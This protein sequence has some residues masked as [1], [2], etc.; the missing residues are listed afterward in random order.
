MSKQDN[1][2]DFLTDVA[3]AIREKKGSSDLI[4]PQNFSEEI[5]NLPSGGKRWTG[6]ADVEG[7]KAIGWDDN[8]IAYFQEH[9]VDWDEEYD[10]YFKV[11]D[12]N[13]ALYGVLTA[14]NIQGYKN[15]IVYLP[16]ID[17]SAR[18]SFSNFFNN[19]FSLIA[20]PFLDTSNAENMSNM[21]GQCYSVKCI[22][23]MET[24]K[25]INMSNMFTR[26]YSIKFI[27][28]LSTISATNMS[29]MFYLCISLKKVQQ[30]DTSKAT[31]INSMFA[32][33][34][35]IE[36][37]PPLSTSSTSNFGYL[38]DSCNSMRDVPSLDVLKATNVSGLFNNCN[39]LAHIKIKNLA[40]SVSAS[41]ASL[42]SKDSLLYMIN[43]EAATSAI[44]ITL[45]SYA[46][47]RLAEDADIVEAL[48]N[49]P[50]VTLASA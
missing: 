40:M 49:H 17:T 43:N 45:H 35:S 2:T 25:V 18:K 3:N 48:S 8:D 4:N 30:I 31:T 19:C 33:C 13:K 46:Y 38:F 11:S 24:S 21:F 14:D 26:C 15:R 39:N 1:L 12:D 7:L 6:H 20:V 16:K 5:K 34:Y 44:T 27:P 23:P 22:P 9:G 36:F 50:L 47:S 29:N 37:I 42:I 41:T 10:D 32:A 28:T